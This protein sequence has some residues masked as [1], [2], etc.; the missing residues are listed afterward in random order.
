MEPGQY[1]PIFASL[2]NTLSHGFR[3]PGTDSERPPVAKHGLYSLSRRLKKMMAQLALGLGMLALFVT[4]TYNTM[5]D[6]IYADNLQRLHKSNLQLI[7]SLKPLSS[8]L[9]S[10]EYLL[11]SRKKYGESYV[12]INKQFHHITSSANSGPQGS[13]SIDPETSLAQ[14]LLAEF[15][16]HENQPNIFINGHFNHNSIEQ[17][18]A[19]DTIPGTPYILILSTRHEH[20]TLGRLLSNISIP[21]ALIIICAGLTLLWAPTLLN[22]T[23]A[24]RVKSKAHNR[25]HPASHD[26]SDELAVELSNAIF[27][28]QLELYFQPKLDFKHNQISGVEA[29]ARWLHPRHG[30]IP[31]EKFIQLAEHNGLI[32]ALT[33]WVLETAIT[34]CAQWQQMGKPLNVSINLSAQNLNDITLPEQ[35]EQ[36]LHQQRVSPALLTLEI[37]ETDIISNPEQTH[38]LLEKL[39]KIGVRIAFDDMGSKS[40]TLNSLHHF[41]VNEIKIDRSV[42]Q[43]IASD[44]KILSSVKASISLARE[45]G[46]EVIAEGVENQ[47]TLELA[48]Q[49]G[50]RFVQGYYVCRPMPSQDLLPVVRA[51]QGGNDIIMR[52]AEKAWLRHSA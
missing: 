14:R 39:K 11:D 6:T 21:L 8:T 26:E 32:Q 7:N 2:A 52:T 34:Q 25:P 4:I 44:E 1:R 18:W 3:H 51:C 46:L 24:W 9:Q 48:Q 35:L 22:K 37:S 43:R 47:H 31:P 40:V 15:L 49:I 33:H 50:C 41:H 13:L 10:I 42:I 36:L 29:L 20:T 19:A 12:V 5:H 28:N 45:Q 38:N 27:D 16:A 17:L 30:F 23:W